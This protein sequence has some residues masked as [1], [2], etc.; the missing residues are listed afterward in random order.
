M[1]MFIENKDESHVDHNDKRFKFMLSILNITN[2]TT[3]VV[4]KSLCVLISYKFVT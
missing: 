4:K 3:L 1:F 2:T